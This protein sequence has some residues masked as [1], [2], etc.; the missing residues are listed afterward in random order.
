MQ[1]IFEPFF[2]HEEIVDICKKVSFA[3]EEKNNDLARYREEFSDGLVGKDFSCV[4]GDSMKVHLTFPSLH[5]LLWTEDGENWYEEYYEALLSTGG[6]VI[7]AHFVRS[8][9]LPHEGAFVVFDMDTGYVTWVTLQVGSDFDEKFTC[10]F[11]HF[12]EIENFGN[13][14]GKPHHFSNDLVGVSIDWEYNEHFTIRH[15]YVSPHLT[16]GPHLPGRDNEYGDESF[17]E[18]GFLRAFHS[19]VRD[20]LLLT[21]FTEPGSCCAVLLI[22]MKTVHD[23]GCFYGVSYY[24]TL[25]SK[26]LT[27]FGGIGKNGLKRQEGY[28]RPENSKT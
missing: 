27:A 1:H 28:K 17:L 11:P 10:S 21:S 15:S 3:P 14:E 26:T 25:D 8:H 7:G 9:T 19:K 5:S 6:N 13:R 23:I 18:R 22:D 20:D 24:G 12:G 4:F 16:I 2:S